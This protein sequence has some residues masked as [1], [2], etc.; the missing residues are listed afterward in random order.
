M[1]DRNA[2]ANTAV[3][4]AGDH[5]DR[6]TRLRFMR[7]DAG[8][9]ETLREFWKVVEPGL[10]AL[11][12][13]FYDHVTRE[14]ELARLIGTQ[15]PRL[16]SAQA[17]H[18]A[19]LFNGRFD[20]EYLVGVRAIGR[21]HNR[22]GLEPRWYI[23]GY[24]LV[25]ARLIALAIRT[26][27]WRAKRLAEVLEALSSAIM[28]DMD[29]AISVYQEAML[30]E[31]QKRQNAVDAAIDHFDAQMRV[32]LQ[33]V[34]SSAAHLQ[35]ASNALAAGAEEATQQTAAVAAASEQASSNVQTVASATEELSSS[36][37][38]IGRQVNESSRVANEAV[39]QA[40]HSSAMMQGLSE[41]AQRIGD[42]VK[43]ISSVAEQTNLLALNA[44][45]EAA[46]AGEA[47][48]GFAVVAQEVKALAA[49]TAKAT[50]EISQHIVGIQ[51]AT[52]DSA[53]AIENVVKTIASVNEIA[54][55]IAS[56]I[57]EQGAATREIARNVSEAAKGTR[58]VSANVSGVSQTAAET[59]QT[60]SK[61][62]NAATELSKQS[63]TLRGEVD[64]FFAKIRAA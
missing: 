4:S 17:T 18:W 16:K 52:R 3:A 63:E 64:G 20:Q 29:I 59:G 34:N 24:N 1:S 25:F 12:E 10:P 58:E 38:E 47:G 23:G 30:E 48:R 40:R 60:A 13:A 6:D 49:Q 22:I 55:T 33:T 19:R 54:T 56:A 21:V 37:T 45:I 11:L 2:I 14:P 5:F 31:R 61:L 36:V 28:L 8:T 32:A 42:V 62:Q 26:Y 15:I 35:S 53:A 41:A 51:Q 7:I 46:R 44:T 27:R 39:S 43:L 9:G 57:E 50:E